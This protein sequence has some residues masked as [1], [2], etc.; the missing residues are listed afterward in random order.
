MP[1][2][3]EEENLN[4]TEWV[5]NSEVQMFLWYAFQYEAT[6]QRKIETNIPVA[7]FLAKSGLTSLE[8][9]YTLHRY[10]LVFKTRMYDP[11]IWW[12]SWYCL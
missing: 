6:Q 2:H 7:W 10:M 3:L 11:K 8:I 12:M 5:T 1:L 4:L 9:V